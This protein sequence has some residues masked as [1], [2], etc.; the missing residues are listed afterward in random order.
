M[1]G[2]ALALSDDQ[3]DWTPVQSAALAQI[4]IADAPKPDQLVFLHVCQ[5]TGLDPFARQIYMIGRK[6]TETNSKKWTIQTGID[7]FRVFSERHPQ[8][9][10]TGDPEWCGKDGVWRAVWLDDEPPAAA[11]F[12]VYRKDQ[13]R[14]ITAIARYREYV[15]T[16]FDGKPNSMWRKMPA[17]QL[18]KC[19]EALARRRAFPR[20]LA[21]VYTDDEMGQADNP[22]PVKIQ[23]ER[24]DQA[25]PDWD[26]LLKQYA[27]NREKLADLWHLARGMRPNDGEL[28]ERIA[29]AGARLKAEQPQE[30]VEAEPPAAL[31]ELEAFFTHHGIAQPAMVTTALVGRP[32]ASLDQLLPT[33][34]SKLLDD[35]RNIAAEE[36]DQTV[37]TLALIAARAAE[38]PPAGGKQ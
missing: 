34:A 7:G 4:G 27:D 22:P 1:S 35:L 13:E 29:A 6:D 25:G 14:P 15:Q 19:A 38:Q 12:T 37:E 3:Q 26:G 30:A 17:N 36:G 21:N 24:T 9:A 2:G 8:Y 20:D 11:R 16:K 33:E 32:I 5:R 28:L 23:A 10:G 18:A 31:T